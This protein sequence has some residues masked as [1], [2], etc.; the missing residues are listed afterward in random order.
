MNVYIEQNCHLL[1]FPACK[2][3][4]YSIVVGELLSVDPPVSTP[5]EILFLR[6]LY[7]ILLL[8]LFSS[9]ATFLSVI[10]KKRFW[11]KSKQRT[12]LE[13]FIATLSSRFET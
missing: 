11:N 7:C 1:S 12:G 2:H 4:F 13:Q 10:L 8:V 5:D 6:P 3:H 9:E